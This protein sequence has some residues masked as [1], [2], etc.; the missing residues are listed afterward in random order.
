MWVM[1]AAGIPH[2]G[3]L[4][5]TGGGSRIFS[6]FSFFQVEQT[7]SYRDS[8]FVSLAIFI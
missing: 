8:I 6:I 7:E 1:E 4:V 2:I 5:S 3:R